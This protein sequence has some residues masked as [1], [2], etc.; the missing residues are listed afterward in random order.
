M[1]ACLNDWVFSDRVFIETFGY[2]MYTLG[3]TPYQFVLILDVFLGMNVCVV[4]HSLT[5]TV[6]VVM[7]F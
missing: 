7:G 6:C 2:Q 1:F 5:L 4:Y 3:H